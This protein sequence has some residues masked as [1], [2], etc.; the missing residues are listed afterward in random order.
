MV[1]LLVTKLPVNGREKEP[2]SDVVINI[3][4][5]LNNLVTS[6]SIAARDIAFF[7]GLQKLVAIKTEH[8]N[9]WVV[10][11]L[12]RC[13][14]TWT[15]IQTFIHLLQNILQHTDSSHTVV[16]AGSVNLGWIF[17]SSPGRAKAAKAAAT[18][19]SNMFQYKKLHSSYKLVR[20]TV[21]STKKELC[22][23]H[24]NTSN[25]FH[26]WTYITSLGRLLKRNVCPL[27]GS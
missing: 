3:C 10:S 15:L 1:N 19:L 7:D 25:I 22:S 27:S 20:K 24:N 2:S 13:V 23:C 8:D 26:F 9:R 18:V 11:V 12:V 16:S 14:L 5:I 4:G 6:S 17:I 21:N